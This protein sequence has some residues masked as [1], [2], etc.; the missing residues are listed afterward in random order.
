MEYTVS[1]IEAATDQLDWAVRLLIDHQAYIPAITL[2]GAAEEIIGEML[3]AES[4]F[5]QLKSKFA[6]DFGLPEK[7]IS[8]DHLNRVKNWLKHWKDMKDAE[9]VDIE[10]EG[11][12]VQYITRAIAN[13]VL[14]DQSLPSEG[15]RFFEWLKKNRPDIEHAF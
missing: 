15:P 6:K 9:T 1:K 7:V 12:A 8:Q 14:H 11:E 10:L 13:L 2:A 5:H 3:L 4:V